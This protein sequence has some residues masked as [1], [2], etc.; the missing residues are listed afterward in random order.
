MFADNDPGANFDVNKS[1]EAFDPLMKDA[2][3]AVIKRGTASASMLQS[4]LGI[5][6]PKANRLVNQMVSAGFISEPDNKNKRV[7]FITEQEFEERF[8]EDFE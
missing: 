3:R 6:Y 7:I 1:E 5:G 4:Y 2:L 8:G